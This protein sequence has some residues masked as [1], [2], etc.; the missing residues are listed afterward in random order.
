MMSGALV[1][2]VMV[3]LELVVAEFRWLG[4]GSMW[5]AFAVF[6]LD[7]S[8]MKIPSFQDLLMEA[9]QLLAKE[10]HFLPEILMM[11]L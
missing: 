8:R 1:K 11:C 6:H 3:M 7:L 10:S 2:G 9:L 4:L 5:T